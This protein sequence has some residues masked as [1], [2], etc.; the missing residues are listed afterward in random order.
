MKK[1]SLWPWLGG[2]PCQPW[3]TNGWLQAARGWGALL[4]WG[5][6]VGPKA[7][8]AQHPPWEAGWRSE[9]RSTCPPR[10]QEIR[11]QALT[12]PPT[13]HVTVDKSP[14][15]SEPQLTPRVAVRVWLW[16]IWGESQGALFNPPQ[17]VRLKQT[18]HKLGGACAIGLGLSGFAGNPS[19]GVPAQAS[20]LGH[21]R[22]TRPRHRSPQPA[23]PQW[24]SCLADRQLMADSRVS[25]GSVAGG[26]DGE[27]SACSAGDLGSIP[28][29]GRPPG[30]GHGNPLQY[31][32]LENPMDRGAWRAIVH[33][34]LRSWAHILQVKK[35][36]LQQGQRL[37]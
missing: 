35:L 21:E 31:S 3:E 13:G 9:R 33:E 25:P 23:N 17:P 2:E 20:L 12:P 22:D 4:S 6:A 10:S 16:H 15:L 34:S 24:R 26:S 28:G 36:R 11:V 14:C 27:E 1:W 19:P 29:W 18:W 5:W 7:Q 8:E 32:C 37:A 30:G